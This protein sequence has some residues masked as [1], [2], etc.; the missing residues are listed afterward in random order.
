ML[1]YQSARDSV[2]ID[3]ILAQLSWNYYLLSDW[4]SEVSSAE[5]YLM[6]GNITLLKDHP[7]GGHRP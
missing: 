7:W 5:R 3:K 2:S 6:P 1:Q 4:I